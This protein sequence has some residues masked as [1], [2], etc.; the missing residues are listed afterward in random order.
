[1]LFAER[2]PIRAWAACGLPLV[3][4]FAA[5]VGA[6][7]AD[8]C[9]AGPYDPCNEV[10]KV[11]PEVMRLHSNES[12]VTKVQSWA[13]TLTESEARSTSSSGF[14]ISLPEIG[15]VG[16]NTSDEQWSKYYQKVEAGTIS[17]L[18]HK[19]VVDLFTSKPNEFALA[20]WRDCMLGRKKTGLVLD[21][22]KI[23]GSTKT[24]SIRYVADPEND[25]A[26]DSAHISSWRATWPGMSGGE[27]KKGI[28]LTVKRAAQ[29]LTC[30]GLPLDKPVTLWVI[31]DGV[32]PLV[33]EYPVIAKPKRMEWIVD[34]RI[35]EFTMNH[36]SGSPRIES[37]NDLTLT[38][39]G[40]TIACGSYGPYSGQVRPTGSFRFVTPL[41]KGGRSDRPLPET[42]NVRVQLHNSALGPRNTPDFWHTLNSSSVAR[43][44][45]KGKNEIGRGGQYDFTAYEI[46]GIYVAE[47]SILIESFFREASP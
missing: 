19:K 37:S 23:A 5:I 7:T 12:L 18:S 2:L 8:G 20:M 3:L 43:E 6:P 40:Q 17:D 11:V 36:A 31:A 10:L 25:N 9:Q 39:N 32:T 26:P 21:D 29:T 38:V 44:K 27:Y 16:S 33:R 4:I 28:N 30:E 42:L 34:V 45:L 13:N 46:K 1:M 22:E 14:S 15:G 41:Y 35:G 47:A 24:L